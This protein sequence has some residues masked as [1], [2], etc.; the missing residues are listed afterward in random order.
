MDLG[1]VLEADESGPSASADIGVFD[2]IEWEVDK[3]ADATSHR[4]ELDFPGFSTTSGDASSGIAPPPPLLSLPEELFSSFQTDSGDAGSPFLNLNSGLAPALV[5]SGEAAE[6][7]N[8]TTANE[9]A[10]L[11]SGQEDSG[12]PRLVDPM[13]RPWATPAGASPQIGLSARQKRTRLAAAG[14][15]AATVVG[16]VWLVQDPG[17]PRTLE[18][19]LPQPTTSTVSVPAQTPV[20]PPTPAAAGQPP[21]TPTAANEP[22]AEPG[23][24]SAPGFSPQPARAPATGNVA[25]AP[26]G[27]ASVRA[28]AT[29][30]S[31][32]PSNASPAS[33]PPS[34]APAAPAGEADA[35]SEPPEQPKS[36][37]RSEVSATTE[38][39][40]TT[41]PERPTT[42][43]TIAPEPEPAP[44]PTAPPPTAPPPTTGPTPPT[45][46]L[47]PS[48]GPTRPCFEGTPPRP[49]DC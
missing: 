48:P 2:P 26:P 28:P 31:S 34:S 11:E 23:P 22:G 45:T 37:R 33:S 30:A 25:L 21:D 17:R 10:S 8:V 5:V 46:V 15:A 4:E 3:K 49:A 27:T 20:P 41:M 6:S 44:P 7:P 16:A 43:T 42:A 35:V 9:T 36:E 38:Q 32:G 14:M 29:V 13:G 18:T 1:F 24:A 12:P 47:P 39:P 19:A 40:T